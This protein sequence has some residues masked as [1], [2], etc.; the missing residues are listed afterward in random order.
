M[1]R[2]KESANKT[3]EVSFDA[4]Y[5][6]MEAELDRRLKK[7]NKEILRM[8]VERRV[9]AAQV[10]GLTLREFRVRSHWTTFF[11]TGYNFSS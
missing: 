4:V 6:L 1:P 10:K 7:Y 9:L 8:F 5:S 3:V 11:L 2:S